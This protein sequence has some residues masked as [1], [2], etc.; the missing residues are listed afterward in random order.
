MV[1]AP[2]EQVRN[3]P[4]VNANEMPEFMPYRKKIE[5]TMIII[6]MSS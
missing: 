1:R 2:V 6:N 4:Q 5:D 3:S